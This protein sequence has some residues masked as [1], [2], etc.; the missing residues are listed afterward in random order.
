MEDIAKDLDILKYGDGEYDRQGN[1]VITLKDSDDFGR[2]N[3]LL[4]RNKDA[5]TMESNS[6]ITYDNASML[7]RYYKD[8]KKYQ[9]NLLADFDSDLYKVVISEI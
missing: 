6:L 3:M 1:Y 2:V 4:S 7:Y 5:Q 9:L 8:N